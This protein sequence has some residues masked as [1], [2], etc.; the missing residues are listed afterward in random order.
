[1][2]F[3]NN[4]RKHRS[5]RLMFRIPLRVSGVTET[6]ESFESLGHAVAVNRFG[7]HIR[8]E[9]PAPISDKVLLTNLENNQRGE[10]RIVR[11]LETSPAGITDIG[12]EALGN[13]PTFWGIGFSAKPGK[14]DES[15]GLLECLQCCS[16]TLHP[17]M[18]DE[19]E[20]LESGGTVKKPCA[21]CGSKTEWK[22][23]IE[24]VQSTL[25][26]A[27]SAAWDEDR[28]VAP[29]Q[30]GK[31]AVVMQRPV[32]IRTASGQVEAVLTE[33]L[34]KNEIRCTSEKS[35]EVNQVVTLEWE[36]T[37][38]GR[39]IQTQGRI[40]RRQSIAGSARVLYCIRY[41]GPPNVL[42]PAPLKSA[43]KLYASLAV[44]VAAAS[45]LLAINVRGLVLN[46]AISPGFEARRVAYLSAALLMVLLAYKA[47]K[48]VLAREPEN[49]QM[50][51]KRHRVITGVVAA[52][53]LGS[54]GTGILDGIGREYQR[55]QTLKVLH[56]IAMARIF[57]SNVDAAENRVMDGSEDYAD[58]C[59]TLALLAAKWQ[60]H[61]DTL[62][63]DA[64]KLYR[65]QLWHNAKSREKMNG[66]EE[67]LALD[68][69]KL[70]VVKE[71]ID[72][73]AAAKNVS[74]NRQLVFWRSSFPSLRQ[75]ILE[76]NS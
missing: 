40:R 26:D 13:Y 21:L 3:K 33:N 15:R 1:M 35:Y 67:I 32:S 72:L 11:T 41:E 10:F 49:R 14:H 64:M 54:L 56:D 18:L 65:V 7:A 31:P 75:K 16:V 57:E 38:T 69:R 55:Q 23:A 24:G 61:L 43:R 47:W 46:M 48:M 68:R 73:K 34:S 52:V 39:R 27:S 66:L 50:I 62:S 51:R 25:Q 70:R 6:G 2:A 17:L 76:L 44:L 29:D 30:H 53:F 58:V 71:Q 42:P 59:A 8:L 36:S 9:R 22:F 4:S 20:V 19:I 63:T 45:V 12:V 5:D 37:G 74:A 60:T 28:A